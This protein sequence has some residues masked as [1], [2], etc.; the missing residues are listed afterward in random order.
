M[1]SLLSLKTLA[2]LFHDE[3]LSKLHLDFWMDYITCNLSY[4]YYIDFLR[5]NNFL[6]IYFHGYFLYTWF[7]FYFFINGSLVSL[8]WKQ[9]TL[10]LIFF[11]FFIEHYA[12]FVTSFSLSCILYIF[13]LCCSFYLSFFFV[14]FIIHTNELKK[15]GIEITF[16]SIQ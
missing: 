3:F 2:F 8:C 1:L 15:T 14:K 5:G 9:L 12:C 10:L 6:I 11:P 4:I 16:M 7:Y 13:I